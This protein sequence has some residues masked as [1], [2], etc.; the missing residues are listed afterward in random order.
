MCWQSLEDFLR[1]AANVVGV[2]VSGKNG[3]G[4]IVNALYNRR[5]LLDY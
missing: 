1:R 5:M 2:D 3:I 4:Q